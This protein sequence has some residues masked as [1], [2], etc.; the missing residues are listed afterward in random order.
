MEG[1]IPPLQAALRPSFLPA[2]V[3]S[4]TSFATHPAPSTAQAP[5]AEEQAALRPS[6]RHRHA[7]SADA[8]LALLRELSE[9][10][11]SR[12]GE[13]EQEEQG[14]IA[15]LEKNGWT[16]QATTNGVC[17]FYSQDPHAGSSS[18]ISAVEQ[19][20]SVRTNGG[21]S[22]FVSPSLFNA[23]DPSTPRGAAGPASRGLRA[24]ET[25]PFFRG[26]GWIEGAWRREDVAATINSMGARSVWDPRVDSSK[27]FVAEHLDGQASLVHLSFRGTL[28]ADRDACIVTTLAADDRPGTNVLYV[29]STSV[30]D[31]LLPRTGNRTKIALNGF[32]LRSLPQPP[33]FETPLP[34]PL[35]E[36]AK[37]ASPP[38]RPSHR[39]TRSTMSAMQAGRDTSPLPALPPLPSLPSEPTSPPTRPTLLASATHIGNL[40]QPQPLKSPPLQHGLSCSTSFTG[41]ISNGD[42][43]LS[44]PPFKPALPNPPTAKRSSLSKPTPRG[45]GLAV[46]MVVRAAPGYNLP[47]TVVNQLSV[48]L[49]LSIASVARF[50]S[51]HGFA[52]HIDR[53]DNLVRIREEQFDPVA[54]RY[55]VIFNLRRDVPASGSIRIRFHG[56]S[57]GRERVELELE[58]VKPGGFSV[59]FDQVAGQH[60]EKQEQEEVEG[61]GSSMWRTRVCLSLE[62]LSFR[63]NRKSSTTSLLSPIGSDDLTPPTSV[64]GGCTLVISS[65]ALDPFLPVVISITRPSTDSTAL[66]LSKMRNASSALAQAASVAL[67]ENRSL[68]DSVEELLESGIEGGEEQAEMGLKRARIVLRELA[69]AQEREEAGK[70]S[71]LEGW[72]FP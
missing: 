65:S 42:S 69:D 38:I 58:H 67:D 60:K 55:R 24:D 54:G 71:G 53:S 14:I 52:P 32:A 51:T 18:S 7:R 66:P 36:T 6:P 21:R 35:P 72:A 16:H 40:S 26:E 3:S 43:P 45:P 30:E 59:E 62:D 23:N 27:S 49:P 61:P 68:C 10:A 13:T 15:R 9:Q 37:S 50:L 41:S 29:A 34:A 64:V 22:A 12:N 25:L 31:P 39:R 33:E 2:T 8:A 70:R 5:G 56:A 19:A 1:P 44:P 20:R 47:Q 28:V 46:S 48:H 4:P 63:Q 11:W 57:F 17:I